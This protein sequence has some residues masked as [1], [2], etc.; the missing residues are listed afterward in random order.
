MKD[1]E[2]V[3][4]FVIEKLEQR[5]SEAQGRASDP[6]WTSGRHTPMKWAASAFSAATRI[7]RDSPP[8]PDES[9]RDYFARM[10]S[11]VRA[12]RD[13]GPDLDDEAWFSSAIDEACVVI[14]SAARELTIEKH[15]DSGPVR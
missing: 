6:Y 13:D 14:S 3:R 10:S 11:A 5:W 9:A 1:I 2:Q 4:A 12:R 15:H 8:A 7:V